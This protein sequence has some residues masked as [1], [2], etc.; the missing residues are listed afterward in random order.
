MLPIEEIFFVVGQWVNVCVSSEPKMLFSCLCV[1][2]I[3]KASFSRLVSKRNCLFSPRRSSFKLSTS[4]RV[5]LFTMGRRGFSP[6]RSS[7]SWWA[8]TASLPKRSRCLKRH[9]TC[10]DLQLCLRRKLL[11]ISLGVVGQFHGGL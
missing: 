9:D 11:F 3:Y 4:V 10:D 2:L 6:P 7:S 8:R 5:E 1:S